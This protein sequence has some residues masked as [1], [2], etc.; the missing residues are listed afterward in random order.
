VFI[1]LALFACHCISNKG[2]EWG[3]G[4]RPHTSPPTILLQFPARDFDAWPY[5]APY[6]FRKKNGSL[7]STLVF[8]SL[9][10]DPESKEPTH[11]IAQV[12]AM[13]PAVVAT[14]ADDMKA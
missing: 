10:W 14:D 11:I 12:T 5:R 13:R 3:F 4:C 6:I 2:S 1:H 8:F 7:L 9:L